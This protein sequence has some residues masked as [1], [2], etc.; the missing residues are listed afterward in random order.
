MLGVS[1]DDG[2]SDDSFR[3][4]MREALEQSDEIKTVDD[5]LWQSL[6]QRLFFISADLT[7]AEEYGKIG[8]RLNEI[9]KSRPEDARNRLFYLAV[10]PSVFEAIVRDLS[11]SGL[12]PRTKSA[13]A[14]PWVRV[15]IEKPFG[16]SLETA[17]H[18][19]ELVLSL[20]HEHQVYRIDH[21][22]GKETV[23]NVLVLRFANSIFE[24]IW[25]RQ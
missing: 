2:Q 16:R 10:P 9:E 14:R 5:E 25:N 4:Q 17:M 20:F 7:N 23:Q 1:R 12:A 22:L 13:D 18:L 8:Q 3:A 15:V 24:P 21:Y 11:S 6:C 19:N